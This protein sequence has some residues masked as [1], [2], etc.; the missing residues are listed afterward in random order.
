MTQER[1]FWNPYIAGIVLGLVLLL[2]FLTMGFGLG[3]SSAAT[4]LAYAGAHA[5]AP[6]PTEHNGYMATYVAE[7]NP[8]EDWMIFEVIGVFL[9][10]LLGAF[11]AGRLRRPHLL[12]GPRATNLQ[13]VVLAILGGIL[14]GF[15]AR[16]AR[17][18]TSGQALTGGAMLSVGSWI[19]MMAVFAGGYLV[20]PFVRRQWR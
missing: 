17:G 8:L 19:Y 11:S 7:G 20:A 9:G 15:A 2:T 10:G 14:M 5:V 12:K 1:P 4:R 13:R 3:S 18:C 16:L 6:A